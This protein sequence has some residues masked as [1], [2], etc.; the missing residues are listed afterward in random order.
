MGHRG[1]ERRRHLLVE[2]HVGDGL[3]DD[4]AGARLADDVRQPSPAGFRQRHPRRVL[5]VRNQ[6]GQ[7]RCQLPDGGLDS[8][9]FPTVGCHRHRHRTQTAVGDRRQRTVI[10]G[11][12]D[13]HPILGLGEGGQD[14]I[15]GVQSAG[16]HHDL[17]RISGKS[18]GAVAFGDRDPQ[19]GY[20][21][22]L[23]PDVVQV[24][25]HLLG[26]LGERSC[27]HGGRRGKGGGG[28][29]RGRR[30]GTG[31]CSGGDRQGSGAAGAAPRVEVAVV[32]QLRVGRGDGRTRD[33]QGIGQCSL[34]GE[35]GT[36]RHPAVDDQQPD[37]VGEAVISRTASIGRPP[38][39]QLT[40]QKVHIQLSR[41]HRA[42]HWGQYC[43]TGY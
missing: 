23:D 28:Q 40:N 25:A 16:G 34:A 20:A 37:G 42:S 22:Q 35:S 11:L 14:Q 30:R 29:V 39:P 5:V 8:V 41:R 15:D 21:E 43:P 7:I 4:G 3:V 26:G 1:A 24:R 6:V 33:T 17:V 9:E 13:E 12:L 2:P 27:H 19:R 36:D 38:V 10:G 32:A 18:T 31:R